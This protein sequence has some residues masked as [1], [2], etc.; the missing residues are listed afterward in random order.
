MNKIKSKFNNTEI[1]V[2]LRDDIDLSVFNEI[3]KYREYKSCENVLQ[4]AVNPVLDIGAHAGFFSIYAYCLNKNVKIFAIEPEKNNLEFLNLHKTENKIENIKI[5][6]CAIG[7]ESRDGELFVSDDSINHKVNSKI[8]KT[9][10]SKLKTQNTRIISLKDFLE[11]NNIKKVSLLKLDIEGGEYD[12]F[13]NIDKD[14]FKRIENIVMEYHKKTNR[15]EKSLE[16]ILREHG[17]SVQ[18][19]PSQFDKTMGFIFAK[20]KKLI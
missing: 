13:E 12:I 11:E 16:K 7:K 5:Y 15:N 4:S 9:I 17:F 19:F 14:V 3:F 6:K 1:S 10:N 2:L 20:N 8:D 18:I